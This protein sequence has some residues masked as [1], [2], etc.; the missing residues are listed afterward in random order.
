MNTPMG[1]VVAPT[2]DGEV[3]PPEEFAK[4]P[5]AERQALQKSIEAIGDELR[6]HAEEAPR[7][8]HDARRRVRE[9]V[10]QTIRLAVKH[11]IDE[12]VARYR[13]LPAVVEH[14]TALSD[15][16]VEHGAEFVKGED[17]SGET[18]MGEPTESQYRR[19]QVN[20][21]VDN[22][23]TAG[24]PV[25]YEDHPTIENLL[26]RVGY[27]SRQGTLVTELQ[28]IKAGALHRANGG[29]LIL[30]ARNLLMQPMA[31]DALKRALLRKQV[32]IESLGQMVSLVT[33]V[34]LEPEAVPLDV[35][36]VLL[37]E[38]VLF[39]MMEQLEPD[40]RAL[41]K[42]AV[43]FEDDVERSPDNGL[44]YAR[45]IAAVARDAKLRPLDCAGGLGRARTVRPRRGG[46]RQAHR[47]HGRPRGSPP[48]GGSRGG[49]ACRDGSFPP[50]SVNRR[51]ED[52]LDEFARIRD[53]A[54]RNSA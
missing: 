25:V 38:R 18:A 10:Q 15:Q 53:L 50:G 8:H 33:T 29:Y 39:Y 34:S 2:K 23:A 27:A 37:G 31:W 26:G 16:V 13:A 40:F 46:P 5:E 42:V 32:R 48:R 4:L 21:L 35:K 20:L 1:L 14:L 45:V 47:Q 44:L 3:M 12:L 52:R 36:V 54:A 22:A 7:W 17:A 28:L 30:D 49:R 43:D 19:Y 11:L 9:L 41:F 6:R 51:V 24:A